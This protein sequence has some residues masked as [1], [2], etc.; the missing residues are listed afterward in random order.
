MG[1]GNTKLSNV[2]HGTKIEVCQMH[3]KITVQIEGNFI[4]VSRKISNEIEIDL[5]I[6]P[7]NEMLQR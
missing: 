3:S 1:D 7:S 2:C 4:V 5:Q 6:R